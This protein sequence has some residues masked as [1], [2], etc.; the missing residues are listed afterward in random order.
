MEII[1][2]TTISFLNNPEKDWVKEE[3]LQMKIDF[4]HVI[5]N[6]CVF[7]FLFDNHKEKYFVY[8]CVLYVE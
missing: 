2:S 6:S 4:A 8:Q 3:E 5:V 1:D 7:F